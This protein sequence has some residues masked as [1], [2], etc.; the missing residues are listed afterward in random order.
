[1]ATELPLTSL[2]MLFGKTA[3]NAEN[4]KKMNKNEM[5]KKTNKKIKMSKKKKRERRK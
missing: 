4:K 1:M 5:N 2:P 3:M